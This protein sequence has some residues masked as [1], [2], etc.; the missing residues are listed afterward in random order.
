[1]ALIFLGGQLAVCY[2]P[3]IMVTTVRGAIAKHN[4]SFGIGTLHKEVL[5]LVG[6][7]WPYWLWKFS[8]W[9]VFKMFFHFLV[10]LFFWFLLI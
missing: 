3:K 6:R 10:L 5:F 4:T 8:W 7:T 2:S 1:M 9:V